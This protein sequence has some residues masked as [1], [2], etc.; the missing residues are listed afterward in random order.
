[1]EK[2]PF[3]DEAVTLK[4]GTGPPV[5]VAVPARKLLPF[6]LIAVKLSATLSGKRSLAP[7]TELGWFGWS[8]FETTA[9]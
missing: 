6:P 5:V 9:S 8:A 1:M 4:V 7:W 3:D 2:T